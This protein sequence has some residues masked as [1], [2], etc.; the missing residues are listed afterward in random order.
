M[1]AGPGRDDPGAPIGGERRY[2][3]IALP[4]GAPVRRLLPWVRR[5]SPWVATDG[6]DGLIL[7][8]TAWGQVHRTARAQMDDA[9]ARLSAVL[10]AARIAVAPTRG[11]A[12]ALARHGAW[13]PVLAGPY[14]VGPALGPMPV[15][16]LRLSAAT[17]R[18]LDGIAIRDIATL[19]QVP[20]LWL[21]RRLTGP[22]P[23]ENPLLR[24]DQTFGRHPEPVDWPDAPAPVA[25]SAVV[26]PDPDLESATADLVDRMARRL[27]SQGL[28]AHELELTLFST[29]GRAVLA[30]AWLRAA[31]N[32]AGLLFAALLPVLPRLARTDALSLAARRVGPVRPLLVATP[33]ARKSPHPP[34]L[35]P[36][37]DV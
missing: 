3:S 22:V 27:A 8:V 1:G 7:D 30:R 20:R 17:V 19:R 26:P 23:A 4:T 35:A 21:E 11:A 33:V 29:D 24:L 5:F 16:A 37:A 15:A 9:A 6:P 32:H 34:L 13:S 31:T 10:P 25:V 28:G 36:A 18:R 2:L 12:W 14:D